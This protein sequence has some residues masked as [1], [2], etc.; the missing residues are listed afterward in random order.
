MVST[1]HSIDFR[2]GYKKADSIKWLKKN[3]IKP[4]KED[5]TKE[6]RKIISIRYRIKDPSLFRSFSTKSI[7]DKHGKVNIIIGYY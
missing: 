4:I 2:E 7:Y 3:N 6:G 5:I 1:I